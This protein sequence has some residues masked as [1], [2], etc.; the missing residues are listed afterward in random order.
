MLI[1]GA[2]VSGTGFDTL[3]VIRYA[4]GLADCARQLLG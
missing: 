3:T 1:A 4:C 2:V